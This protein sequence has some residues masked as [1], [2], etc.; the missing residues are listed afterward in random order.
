MTILAMATTC[1]APIEVHNVFEKVIDYYAQA[2]PLM[3]RSL[4][5]LEP[6]R[7][8]SK[9]EAVKLLTDKFRDLDYG[10]SLSISV[11]DNDIVFVNQIS[12]DMSQYP[13]PPPGAMFIVDVVGSAGSIRKNLSWSAPKVKVASSEKMLFPT[14]DSEV[15]TFG[16][17]EIRLLEA[18]SC[19]ELFRQNADNRK[20]AACITSSLRGHYFQ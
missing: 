13:S 20:V 18:E 12:R 1:C 15:Q 11:V 16:Y 10:D 6:E 5:T 9:D 4:I 8:L 19:V 3:G 7:R 2:A 14:I 17:Q